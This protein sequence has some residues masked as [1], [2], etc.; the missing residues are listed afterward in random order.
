MICLG[1]LLLFVG[2]FLVQSWLAPTPHS[3]PP[4]AAALSMRGEDHARSLFQRETMPRKRELQST[5][6][7][8]FDEE[9]LGGL[10]KVFFIEPGFGEKAQ[11]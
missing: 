2:L 1:L 8:D 5:E 7:G 9:D 6:S 4:K 11:K 3:R 10:S